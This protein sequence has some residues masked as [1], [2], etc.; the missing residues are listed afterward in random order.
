MVPAMPMRLEEPMTEAT[1]QA[2]S[3]PELA[4]RVRGLHKAFGKVRALDGVDLSVAP[5]TV[6]GLLGPNGA[7]KTTAVRVMATLLR[8]DAGEV[9]VAGLD[10]VRD[11]VKVRER[12]GL[13]GQYAA[14]DENLTGLENLV[15]V[16]RLYGMSRGA[17]T[18][19]AREL[20]DGFDLAEAAGRPAKTYS[21][22]M[23]RRL[24]LGAALV[25]K[26]PV[27]FLD[28]PTTGLDPRSR[29]DVWTTIE[30]LVAEGRTVLL[31]T[32]YLDEADR[33]ADSIAVIDRG[34]VIAEGTPDELKDRVGGERL[35]VRLAARSDA[36]A[37]VR[38]LNALS[39]EPPHADGDTVTVGVRRRAG[40]I[41]DAVRRLDEA[42][43]GVDDI[44]LRRPTLDDVF[45]SL[46]G[47]AAEADADADTDADDHTDARREES[48]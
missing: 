39:D 9:R 36:Q 23:R 45:L 10:V 31:T 41:V 15:M 19:R 21:G 18:V 1:T 48:A 3:E 22:G 32:Q 34:R 16:G 35:E 25:A 8:P 11:A 43:V 5:G 37:A 17:A 30:E 40:V 27:L 46:T 13:A 14:I 44:A 33:L 28:E 38:A 20:L 2:A 6:L 47:H 24:D 29:L 42:G 26:P 12:I 4:I 7:G